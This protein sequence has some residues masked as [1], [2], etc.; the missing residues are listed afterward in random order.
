MSDPLLS[1]IVVPVAGPD[2]ARATC[3]AALPHLKEAGGTLTA[4]YVVEKA[5]GA[6]DKASVEQREEFAQEAFDVVTEACE[7]EGV[8]CET[9]IRYDTDVVDAI[10]RAARERDATSIVFSP[11][12]GSRWTDLLSGNL[13]AKLVKRADRPVVVFPADEDDR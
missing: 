8:D 13:S 12:R 11:R 9:E 1:R 5:G 2:D 6:I 4:V 3:E 10:F 7:R